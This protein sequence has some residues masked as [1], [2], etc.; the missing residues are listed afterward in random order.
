VIRFLAE[1]GLAF[2]DENEVLRCSNNGNYLGLLELI[3]KFDPFLKKNLEIHANKGRGYISY[4]S[5]T[6]CEEFIKLLA[7]ELFRKIISE[8]QEVK[9]FA[10]IIDSTPDLS[11]VD[12][13][14]IIIRYCLKGSVIERFLCFLPIHSHTSE[15]LSSEVRLC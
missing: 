5:K 14:T 12:Q 9:Y 11:H 2:R 7:E 3:A 15:S 4:I 13:L 8:I 1:R 6:T 10:L